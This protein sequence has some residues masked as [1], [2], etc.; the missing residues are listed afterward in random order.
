M[1]DVLMVIGFALAMVIN[2]LQGYWEQKALSQKAEARHR[3]RERTVLGS[4]PM[5]L[6][7]DSPGKV[8]EGEVITVNP[9]NEGR[10]VRTLELARLSVGLTVDGLGPSPDGIEFWSDASVI[11]DAVPEALDSIEPVVRGTLQ[12]YDLDVDPVIAL[13]ARDPIEIA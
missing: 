11:L 4:E 10:G 3:S 8:V 13:P 6:A 5:A 7:Y 9:T 1:T 2:V 12:V